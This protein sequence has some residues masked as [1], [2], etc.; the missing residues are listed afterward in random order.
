VKERGPVIPARIPDD[1]SLL[2]RTGS[3]KR[4]PGGVA[5][6]PLLFRD[7]MIGVL[8]LAG[9]RPFPPE[10]IRLMQLLSDQIALVF[11][12]ERIVTKSNLMAEELS[13]KE[14][15]LQ[16]HDDELLRKSEELFNQDLELI[17]KDERLKNAEKLK[18][19]F[20]E[21]MS[22]ELRTPLNLMIHH[23][24]GALSNEDEDS[25]SAESL[26]HLRAALGEGSAFSR[27][28]N[29]IVDLWRIKE[30]QLRTDSKEIHFE[31]VIDEAIHHVQQLAIERNVK[32]EKD[33]EG[34][35]E[36]VRTDLAKLTQVMT[37][38]IGNAVKF[39]LQGTV[40]ITAEK[41]EE[42]LVCQVADTGIGIAT[43]DLKKV[44]EEFFQ[45]DESATSGFRGAGLG[46][47]VAK[48]LMELLGGSIDVT[49]EI[50]RGTTVTVTVRSSGPA[51]DVKG[52]T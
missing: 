23:L 41:N 1:A 49:S 30:G 19:D 46:L 8:V 29:N 11:A 48:K 26:A 21:K 24:I 9:L 17:E 16:G 42:G 36:P 4:K 6:H 28:L 40:A 27:T 44:F 7:K 45:V 18:H 38:V 31:A 32:I 34:A 10:D 33:L 47:S 5:A 14:K 20:L 52:S 25:M 51:G 43:D 37:E 39:T 12:Q 2:I 13:L 50:G 35:T 3:W 15:L 22:R